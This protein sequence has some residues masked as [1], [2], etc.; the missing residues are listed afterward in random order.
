MDALPTVPV[1]LLCTL[2]QAEMAA[3]ARSGSQCGMSVGTPLTAK[4]LRQRQAE[5]PLECIGLEQQHVA[6]MVDLSLAT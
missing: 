5:K 6:F 4:L 3:L 2:W 1:E